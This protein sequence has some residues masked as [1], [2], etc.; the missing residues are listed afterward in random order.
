MQ[1]VRIVTPRVEPKSSELVF[2]FHEQSG[3]NL[4]QV[5]FLALMISALCKVQTVGFEKLASAFDSNADT[6]SCLQRIQRFTATYRLDTDLIAKLIFRLV[7]ART[8]WRFGQ[9]NINVLVVAVVYR[10]VYFPLLFKLL[11]KFANSFIHQ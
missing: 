4:A 7:I 8:I 10:G 1:I 3:W 2:I 5:N 9:Q 6:C 11:P